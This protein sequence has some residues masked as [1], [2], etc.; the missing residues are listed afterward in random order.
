M[1]SVL[2]IDYGWLQ[3]GG[4]YIAISEQLWINYMLNT[5]NFL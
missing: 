2:L 4:F 1:F 5:T 3:F